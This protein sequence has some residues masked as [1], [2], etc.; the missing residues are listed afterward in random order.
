MFYQTI[1]ILSFIFLSVDSTANVERT[2]A[3]LVFPLGEGRKSI[4]EP[5]QIVYIIKSDTISHHIVLEIEGKLYPNTDDFHIIPYDTEFTASRAYLYLIK[6][7]NNLWNQDILIEARNLYQFAKNICALFPRHVL[8]E[9][10]YAL[11]CRYSEE[12]ESISSDGMTN[13][14]ESI[15]ILN[16]YLHDYPNGKYK[17]QIEWQLLRLKNSMYEYEGYAEGPLAQAKAYET[18]LQSHIHSI[19][20][21][22]IRLEIARLY[23]IA[24][25][26]IERKYKDNKLDGFFAEDAIKFQSKAVA[27]YKLLINSPDLKIRES[28]KVSLFNISHNRKTYIGDNDW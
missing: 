23:R 26:C 2:K 8:H 20:S 15:S 17:D 19:F 10:I 27:I 24:S 6:R 18:F 1:L 5:G 3:V 16:K 11:L 22:V 12:F 13:Y 25:E 14:A 4:G 7:E 21:D 28:A 9:D